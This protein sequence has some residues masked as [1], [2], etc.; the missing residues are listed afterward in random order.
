MPKPL[1]ITLTVL[2]VP[3]GV[4]L[5]V[6]AGFLG[7]RLSN[8]GQVL[9]RVA[10]AD[11]EL[12]D[13][14]Y[15]DALAALRRFEDR[16]RN[17]PVPVT[18]AGRTFALDPR[19]VSFEI[20]EA[21]IAARAMEQGRE[22]HLG[23]Q[24]AWWVSHFF[25]DETRRLDMP[26]TYDA[27]ALDEIIAAWEVEGI[28]NP[29]FPGEVTVVNGQ[30]SFRHPEA[31]VGIERETAAAMLGAALGDPAR[32][33]VALPSRPLPPPL[34]D[35]DIDAVVAE[36]Q[37]LITEDVALTA[38]PVSDE[39]VIPASVLGRSLS[40]SRDDTVSPPAFAFAW[41]PAP[42]QSALRP[43]MTSLSTEPVNAEMT[44]DIETDEVKI[45]PSI[46]VQEPDPDVLVAEVDAA[47]RSTTRRGNLAYRDGAEPDVTTAD[48]EA[49]GIRG[50]IGEFTT[51]HHCC[52]SRV[53]NIHLIAAATDGAMVMPGE[54][55]DLNEHVGQRTFAKGY[56]LAPA[57]VRGALS[58]CDDPANIGG[59][60]SQFTT[61][62]YNATFFAGLED[63][64]HQ[65]HTEVISRYPEGREATLGWP[66][67]NL[68]FLNN[69]GH[70][71][72]IRTTFDDTSV[73]AKIY[74]DNNGIKV[75][76]G[77]D[78]DQPVSAE[79]AMD[80]QA[81][82]QLAAGY[83]YNFTGM[84]TRREDNP[85]LACGTEQVK[86]EGTGGWSIDYYRFITYPDGSR[87]TEEWSWHYPG[88]FEIIEVGPECPPPTP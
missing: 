2:L 82:N 77:F 75:E 42:L 35:A 6:G 36:A 49:L 78:P 69:T 50:L 84:I 48:L 16:L 83:R 73:T 22:G 26:Y 67:P 72:I 70:A 46:N 79:V 12:G 33:E 20:D 81:W 29:P 9:G 65:P 31:G 58:C 7:D 3:V 10:V 64:L 23:N 87:T 66:L 24:F 88:L 56:V 5:L 47:A 71:L 86:Y 57:I 80:I 39:L 21:A 28:A 11:V 44:I 43:Y 37:S 76:T 59:G 38:E 32:A 41:D 18:V 8:G 63:V 40:V 34:T 51:Y 25:R 19:D 17:T 55:F 14:S 54:V 4:A 45:E 52:E 15:G 13:L 68:R 1:R 27:A 60:T 61:T 62:L 85:E 53:T 30:V 74:G